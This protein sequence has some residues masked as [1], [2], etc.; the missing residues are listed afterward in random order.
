[1]CEYGLSAIEQIE[2]ITGST[3]GRLDNKDAG[4]AATTYYAI[5]IEAAA[6]AC[7]W[8]ARL[9]AMSWRCSTRKMWWR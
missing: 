6:S 9:N 2:P 4:S 1:M 7:A 5:E 3:G 8:M